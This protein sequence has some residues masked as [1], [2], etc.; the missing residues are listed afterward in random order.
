MFVAFERFEYREGLHAPE[1]DGHVDA[2]RGKRLT[3]LR[4]ESHTIDHPSVPF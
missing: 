1:F 4:G 3:T 2:A